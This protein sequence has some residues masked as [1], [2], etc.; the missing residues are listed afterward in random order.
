MWA[1]ISSLP[2]C[3]LCKERRCCNLPGC[4][5]KTGEEPAATGAAGLVPGAA[6]SL[7]AGSHLVSFLS[8]FPWKGW[9]WP[10]WCPR[11]A[12]TELVSLLS[13][14]ASATTYVNVPCAPSSPINCASLLSDTTLTWVAAWCP[15]CLILD[16]PQQRENRLILLQPSHKF[17]R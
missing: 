5:G 13:V 17:W 4:F 9:V 2:C 10:S 3:S 16:S 6:L 15:R 12:N 11:W 14:T 1:R 7:A 8:G